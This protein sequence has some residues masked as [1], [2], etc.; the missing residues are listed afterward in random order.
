MKVSEYIARQFGHPSG[1]GGWLATIVMNLLNKRLYKICCDVVNKK[2]ASTILDIGFGN[3]YALEFLSKRIP[4]AKQ[5]H[6]IDISTDALR[7]AQRRLSTKVVLSIGNIEEMDFGPATFDMVYTIN[8]FY[9]WQNPLTALDE[10]KR[11]LADGGVFLNIAYT[12][13][14]LNK[15]HYTNYGFTKM[16]CEEILDIHRRAGFST[17]KLVE[18]EPGKSFY[19]ICTK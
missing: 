6:G 18:I 3:G 1:F 7:M 11:V 17:T 10:V 4:T 8:T 14:Y 15:L 9:F 2:E 5:L 16:A 12:K 19:I 13:D